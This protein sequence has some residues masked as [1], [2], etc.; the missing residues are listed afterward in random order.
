MT[1]W[2]LD[3]SHSTLGF[4]VRHLMVT[5]VHGRFAKGTASFDDAAN[6]ARA[7]IEVASIDTRDEKRDAHLRSADFFDAEKF[8]T[9][10][11]ES[12]GVTDASGD[13][14]TLQGKLTIHGVTHDVNLAVER[15]GEAKDPWGN[16]RVSF[17]AKTHISRKD[18]GMVWN[19]GLEAGGVLVADRVD[20][21]LDLQFI[22]Q[23]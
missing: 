1:T 19:V 23:A 17:E 9:I 3:L 16:Q 5:K 8:P 18:F 2:N 7:E 13:T 12:T 4:T 6:T 11:F 20:I 21:A 15:I 22:K 14:L 10:T